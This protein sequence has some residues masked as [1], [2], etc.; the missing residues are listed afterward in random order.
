MPGSQ[1]RGLGRLPRR[2]D[3]SSGRERRQGREG[4]VARRQV[5][6]SLFGR[7]LA[8]GELDRGGALRAEAKQALAGMRDALLAL[9]E[10]VV[11]EPAVPAATAL[12][13]AVAWVAVAG[14]APL[15][16]LVGQVSA[17]NRGPAAGRDDR[18]PRE[19]PPAREEV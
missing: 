8:G 10:G 9:P 12:L 16:V 3:V 7:V 17:T 15:E 1:R 19:E 13:V 18:S 11:A 5:R 4:R 2:L 6:L 14:V